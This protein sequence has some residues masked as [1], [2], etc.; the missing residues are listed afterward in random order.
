MV[1]VVSDRKVMVNVV[2][3]EFTFLHKASTV[4]ESAVVNALCQ[5]EPP[6]TLSAMS[7]AGSNLPG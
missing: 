1:T 7:Q 4:S 3:F 2:S 5:D 6:A